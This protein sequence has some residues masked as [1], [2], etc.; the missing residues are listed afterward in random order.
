MAQAQAS[1]QG[2]R[3]SFQ[4]IS[5]TG[6]VAPLYGGTIF[7]FPKGVLQN[8]NWDAQQD[9]GIVQGNRVTIMGRTTGYGTCTGSLELLVSESDDWFFN[10]L[11]SAGAFPV[12]AVY[13]DLNVSY[14]VNGADNRTD[15]LQGCRITKVGA[16]NQKGNDAITKTVDLSIAIPFQNG[17]ALYG[18]PSNQ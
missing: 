2:N 4:D 9:A 7:A 15:L 13:F 8:L 16:A 17:V 5:V 3:F 11:S 18:D 1:Y 6:T 14:S 12:M 10:T